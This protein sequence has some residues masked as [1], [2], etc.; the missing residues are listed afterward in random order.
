MQLENI[1]PNPK[2]VSIE[3]LEAVGHQFMPTYFS[4]CNELLK[5]NGLLAL[6][7]ITSPDARYVKMRHGGILYRNIF[8]Q[9]HCCLL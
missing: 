5:E 4:K 8:S 6:Q 3:M 2:I 1:I 9:D 7:V